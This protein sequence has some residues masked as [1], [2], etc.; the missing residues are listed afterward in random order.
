ML[1][2][3]VDVYL[4]ALR[5][6][7]LELSQHLVVQ[8]SVGQSSDHSFLDFSLIVDEVVMPKSGIGSLLDQL[9]ICTVAHSESMHPGC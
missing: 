8:V 1:G 6:E 2:V 3:E 9:D 5:V 7:D 4:F